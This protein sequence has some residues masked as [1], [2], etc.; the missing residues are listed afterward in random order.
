MIIIA[1]TILTTLDKCVTLIYNIGL[2]HVLQNL[3]FIL[4]VFGDYYRL[5]TPGHYE[6]T[7]S[8]AGYFPVSRAITVPHYQNTA[9]VLN[10][11]LEVTID[12]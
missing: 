1:V 5:L 7:A 8:H 3:T 10:F 12:I 6:V 9:I 2:K 11:R 4:G